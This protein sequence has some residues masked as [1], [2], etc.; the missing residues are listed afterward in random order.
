MLATILI[1]AVIGGLFLAILFRKI[2]KIRNGDWGCSCGGN[3]AS[4]GGCH[5][6]GSKKEE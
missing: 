6:A 5:S 1:L 4:C 2:R 3:C